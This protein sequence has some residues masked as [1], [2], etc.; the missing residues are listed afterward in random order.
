MKLTNTEKFL[1]RSR[2][3]AYQFRKIEA[4]RVLSD[5]GIGERGIRLE[6]GCGNGIGSPL[7]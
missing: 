6:I 7:D 3:R 4:P 2:L 5:L 1:V